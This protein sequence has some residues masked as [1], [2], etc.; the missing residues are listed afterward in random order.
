MK[1]RLFL[2]LMVALLMPFVMK[3]QN[4]NVVLTNTTAC[5]SY[6]W[7]V[8][9]ET[10]TTTTDASVQSGD[11]L[12]MLHVTVNPVYDAPACT[13]SVNG[14]CT[15]TFGDTV[16]SQNGI[17]TR[18]LQTIAGC[19]SVACVNLTVATS[20]AATYT[21]TACASYTWHGHTYTADTN[22]TIT[23]TEGECD[24]TLTLNLTILQPV[25]IH[26]DTAVT[27]CSQVYFQFSTGFPSRSISVTSTST[28]STETYAGTPSSAYYNTFHGRTTERCFDSIRTAN[29]TINYPSFSTVSQVACDQYTFDDDHIYNY[30]KQNDTIHVGSNVLSCDS[31]VVLNVV[32]NKSPIVTISGDLSVTPGSSA[33]LTATC[34]Q[35]NVNL[36]WSTGSTEES[37]VLTNINSNTDV[38]VEATNKTTGC[39]GS[40]YV[41]ILAN[42]GI[43]DVENNLVKLYPNPATSAINVETSNA[44][45]NIAIYNTLGQRIISVNGQ[46]TSIDINRL[47]AGNYAM[48]ITLVDGKVITRNFVVAK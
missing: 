39:K 17:Y 30:S 20:A 9:G 3:A 44:I 43:D 45:S 36:L 40:N 33:N 15:Y 11:T 37:I 23:D 31:S 41:T 32:I 10:Y 7:P 47:N 2:T 8:N 48:R 14:G 5:G 34:N 1:R 12:Y 22:F 25:Q 42:E 38:S 13:T 28:I 18:T 35:S 29:I 16:L 4:Q 26:T 24:S 27:G 6:T 19:D 46:Q 21:K